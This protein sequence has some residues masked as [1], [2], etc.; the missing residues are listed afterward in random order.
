MAV[1]RALLTKLSVLAAK[2]ETTTGTA[3]S[4]TSA[5]GAFNVMDALFVP[6]I[7][8]TRRQGQGSL[9]ELP[10]VPGARS[11]KLTFKHEVF[12]KGAS[13]DP[14]WLTTF[15]GNCGFAVA[16]GTWKPISASSS[17]ATFGGYVDGLKFLMSGCAGKVTFDFEAG[18]PVVGSYEYN[19]LWLPPT[20]VALLAPTYP[21]VIPP[22]FA[23][24]TL[25]WGGSALRIG[26][27]QIIIENTLAMRESGEDSSNTGYHACQITNRQI[28][29]KVSPEASLIATRD[30][31]TAHT[32]GTTYALNCVI[33]SAANNT[34]TFT[35]PR[36][37]LLNPPQQE[38]DNGIFRHGL[39]FLCTSATA[40]SELTIA[41]T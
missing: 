38:D 4:L 33:G 27:M 9:T 36:L 20:D 18:K 37:A 3:E 6:D 17:T 34:I 1:D 26:K 28:T 21:T 14:G 40:D 19:G 5:E 30:F 41:A 23:N 25:T 8:P 2:T 15:I 35:A 29:I 16:A 22:R 12:G 11:G 10:P 7:P 32:A 13:G 39:E 24:S 31:Y